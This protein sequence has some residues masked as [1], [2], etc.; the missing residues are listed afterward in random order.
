MQTFMDVCSTRSSPVYWTSYDVASPSMFHPN[1]LSQRPC[2]CR[3]GVV[4]LRGMQCTDC[5]Y[6]VYPP[7]T[8]RAWLFAHSASAVYSTLQTGYPI[9]SFVDN[10]AGGG[11]GGASHQGLTLV[12]DSAQLELFCPLYNPT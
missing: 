10:C 2:H 4:V 1:I 12:P 11:A 7:C 8:P 9:Y 6:I 3:V 5:L